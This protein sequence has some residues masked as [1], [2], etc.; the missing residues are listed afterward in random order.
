MRLSPE[1]ILFALSSWLVASAA[2]AC[3]CASAFEF[4]ADG[5]LLKRAYDDAA[6]VV[7]LRVSRI[8]SGEVAEIEVIEDFKG[9]SSLKEIVRNTLPSSACGRGPFKVGEEGIFFIRESR[10]VGLCSNR[11]RDKEIVERLRR[12]RP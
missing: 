1:S 9:G 10:T 3:S 7:H 4:V 6:F 2:A 8:V 11:G 5:E 12:L